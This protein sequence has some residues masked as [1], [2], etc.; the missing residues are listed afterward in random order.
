[1]VLIRPFEKGDSTT[2]LDIEKL[3][4]QG[5][6]NYAMG[7][8]KK[9][10]IAR[11]ELYDNWNVLVA[12]EEGNVV[13][14][15]GWTV[16]HDPRKEETYAYFTEVMVHPEF[17]RKGIA[18]KLDM[19]AEKNVRDIGSAYIY[20]Y[21]FE[22]ND[23]SQ[24]LTEQL[25]WSNV[26][27][28]KLCA[29]SVY[30]KADLAQKFEI[31]RINENDI[32]EA[33]SLINS[34]YSG[35]A[36]FVPYT[37]E[38]FGSYVNKIPAYGLENFWVVKDKGKIAACAGLWD[39]SVMG[40]M[41]FTK[42]PLTWKVMRGVFGLLGLFAKMPKIPAEGEYF[43][44]YYVTDPVFKPESPE[45]MSSLIRYFNN[46]L[47]DAG[48]DFFTCQMDADDPLFDIIKKF[49]PS[50][51]TWYVYAKALEGEPPELSP[52]YIDIRDLVL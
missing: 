10:I 19:E 43:K 28:F 24:A 25:G 22:P 47:L 39:C 7:I 41:C 9:D 4:P 1:M 14:W 38:S 52:L 46:F 11:Y 48:R 51:D 36:H 29:I 33:V 6:E 30:K 40:D 16:K 23:A 5:N 32:P 34:Y 13:G 31:E 27:E 21:I 44:N 35:C 26:G 50:V 3:C 20:G 45:A 37:T 49:K 2:M 18:A 17:R 12:E 42:I 8:D 15:I